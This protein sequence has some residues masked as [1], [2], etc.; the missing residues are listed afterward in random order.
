MDNFDLDEEVLL[1]EW[2][3]SKDRE[4]QNLLSEYGSS[5]KEVREMFPQVLNAVEKRDLATV[6]PN[7][8]IFLS[9]EEAK[10]VGLGLDTGWMLK[11]TPSQKEG[12]RYTSSLITPE[13]WEITEDD[14]FI[15][16]SGEKYTRDEMEQALKL[17]N[18]AV[19]NPEEYAAQQQKAL[20]IEEVFGKVFPKQDV[21]EVINYAQN[22]L[23][24]FYKDIFNIGRNKDTE[25]LLKLLNFTDEE[26]NQF[27]GTTAPVQFQEENWL[28]D[29]VLDPLLSGTVNFAYG[30]SQTF[31]STL[32]S[33]L[34]GLYRKIR[35]LQPAADT[36]LYKQEQVMLNNIEQWSKEQ[37]NRLVKENNDWWQKHPELTPRPEYNENPF[38]KTELL[39][40]PGYYAYSFT[41]SLAY[42]LAT[43]G[44]MVAVSALASP[45]AG[46]PA[47]LIVAGAPEAGRM[48]EE[49]V[50]QGVPIDEANQWGLLYGTVAGGIETITDLP[51]LGI[52]FKPIKQAAKPFW[53]TLLKGTSNRIAKAVITTGVLPSVEGME[54]AVTQAAENAILKHFD[55]TK[56][57]ME[58]LDQSFIQGAI[59]SLPF[60]VVGG[61]ASFSTFHNSLNP[62]IRKKFDEEMAKFQENGLSEEEAQVKAANEVAKTPEGEKAVED[63]LNTAKNEFE[64]QFQNTTMGKIEGTNPKYSVPVGGDFGIGTK[65]PEDVI[66]TVAPLEKL[67]SDEEIIKGMLV[68]NWIRTTV[69]A[70]AKIPKIGKIVEGG[71]GWRTL[72]NR[73]TK[74]T[75]DIVG[76]G[77][78]VYGTIKRTGVG[79]ANTEVGILRNLIEKPVQYFGFNEQG[80]SEKMARRL[81]PQYKEHK[82]IAGTLEHVFTY[83]E[84]YDWT[85]M[86]KAMDYIA[87]VNRINKWVNKLLSDEGA[88]V[89]AV[90]ERWIHRVVTGKTVEGELVEVRGRKGMTGG[91]PGTV[92]SYKKPRKFKTMMEGIQNHII[93]EPNIEV[94]VG[95]Y[96]EEAFKEIASTRFSKSVEEFGVTPKERLLERYPEVAAKAELTKEE[97]A[98]AAKF[99]GVINRAIRGEI[100][101]EATI[102]EMERKFPE[103][104]PKL[105]YY[106]AEAREEA[107]TA[108]NI[109][110]LKEY[111]ITQGKLPSSQKI[112]D[113]LKLIPYDERLTLRSQLLDFV[114]RTNDAG[115]KRILGIISDIDSNPMYI[116][117]TDTKPA[118]PAT[119]PSEKIVGNLPFTEMPISQIKVDPQ[120]FQ[121]K[122]RSSEVTGETGVLAQAKWN[123]ELAGITYGWQAKDG[124]VYIVNGHQRL[125][126]A[127]RSGAKTIPIRIDKEVDGVTEQE[128]RAKGA[129]INI[130]EDRG[131][132]FDVAKFLRDSG[133]DIE[134]L[135]QWGITPEGRLA[136]EGS[137]IAG[138]DDSVYRKVAI[139]ELDE[140]AA[141]IIGKELPGD[142]ANQRAIAKEYLDKQLTYKQLSAIIKEAKWAGTTKVTQATLF[143]ETE[144]E[145]SMLL[146]RAK[147][148]VA[149]EDALAKDKRLFSYVTA[150]GRPEALARGK[151]VVDV[152]TG[153]KLAQE[154]ATALAIFEAKANAVGV[155]DD[156]MRDASEKIAKGG[157]ANVITRETIDRIRD[158][159]NSGEALG[160]TRYVTTDEGGRVPEITPNRG[161]ATPAEAEATRAAEEARAAETVTEAGISE[162]GM[163]QVSAEEI[164]KKFGADIVLVEELIRRGHTIAPDGTMTLYHATTKD[165]AQRILSEGVL[166]TA[167][168]APDTYGVYLSTSPEVAESYGDGTLIKIKVKIKDLHPDDVFPSTGRM[169]FRVNTVSGV[170]HPVEVAQFELTPIVTEAVTPE[171]TEAQLKAKVLE[172]IKDTPEWKKLVR[173]YKAF[174]K[175][176]HGGTIDEEAIT[177][178][179]NNPENL[180]HILT[181]ESGVMD[182]KSS[183][184]KTLKADTDAV[185]KKAGLTRKKQGKF[186]GMDT[187]DWDAYEKKVAGTIYST[188][189]PAVTPEEEILIPRAEPGM[190]EPGLQ[191]D[192]FGYLTPVYPKG[193]GEITQISMDDYSKL[194]DAYKQAEL[195]PPEVEV[196]PQVEGQPGLEEPTE[197]KKETYTKPITKSAEER[198]QELIKLRDE[199][200][201]IVDSRKAPFWQAKH[202]MAEKMEIVRRPDIGE[203]YLMMPFAGGR[204]FNQDFVD[205]VN[206]F[207]GVDKGS[208]TLKFVSDAAGILRIT[209]ASLDFSAM[210]IQGLPSF[211][212]AHTQLI[213]NPATGARLM[214]AWYKALYDSTRAFFSPSVFYG[215]LDKQ[216]KVAAQRNSFGG[217]SRSIDYFD[218]LRT[219][220]AIPE[221]FR[222]VT[223]KTGLAALYE[224]AEISFNSAGEI[225]RDEFWK[226]LSPKALKQGKGFEL[227]RHMD[228][229]TGLSET[230]A[231]GVPLTV[232]QLE[233]SFA[234]FAPN[235]TRA[236][237]TVVAD[238][239]RGGY[240]GKMARQALGGMLAA[241]A[242]YYT[243][244]QLA[245]SLL[246]GK[247]EDDAWDE[248]KKGFGIREDPITGEI[249][250]RPL[251]DLMGIKIGN[252]TFG[253]GG[254]WY[255][256][257]RLAGNINECIN[258]YGDKERID[259][260][261]ILANGGLNKDNPFVYWWYSRSSPL[262]GM[263]YELA[264]H[265]DFLGY[266]IETPEQ[267]AYYIMSRFE[268]IWME[269]GINWM[270]PGLVRNYEIPEGVARAA[271]P[272]LEVFGWRSVP[273]SSW[274]SF[275]DYVNENI[276]N[277]LPESE[278]DP[279]QVKAW[280]DGKLGWGELDKKQKRDLIDRDPELARLYEEANNDSKIRQTPEWEAYTTRTDEEREIYYDRIDELTKRLQAG[281]IDT[282][283]YRELT[284]EAGT[285]YGAIMDGISRDEHYSSIFEYFEKKEAEGSKYEFLFDVALAEY[286]SKIRFAEDADIYLS[287]GDYNWEERDRRIDAFI[288]K[289]GQTLYDEILDYINKGKEIKGLNPVFVRKS[290]DTEKLGREYWRLPYKPIIEM[291][292]EDEKEGNIPAEYYGLW[293]TFQSLA[294]EDKEG[295]AQLYPD[296]AKDWRAE[297]RKNNPEADARL[298]LWGYGGKLQ[299]MEAYNLVEQWSKE[300]GIPLSQ[301]GLGLPPRTLIPKYF[302]YS[303]LL[304]NYSAASPQVKIWRLQNPEFNKWAM[305]EWGWEGT[306]DYRSVEYYQLKIKNQ[307][308]EKEYNAIPSENTIAKQ[309]YLDEHPDFRD[310]RYRMRAMDWG[311]PTELIEQYVEYYNTPRKDY[312][313]DWWLMEHPEFEKAM[314]QLYKDTEGE[315]GWE[316]PRDYSKV[317]TK[318]VYAKYQRYLNLPLG[319]PRL[320]FRARNPDLDA[321]GVKALDWK[322]IQDR[323]KK[324]A[325]K[326]P[327][328]EAGE[329]AQLEEWIKELSQ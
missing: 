248:V 243:G 73:D 236:C 141:A 170:Y 207:F 89:D 194:V 239:F 119:P 58:G 155:I 113:T 305:E 44:T 121:F 255:G 230:Q 157:K 266:P 97:L 61:A 199:V 232:R 234:W 315:Y 53:D 183:T 225:V 46:I 146:A 217:T 57:I 213:S 27:F 17:S 131:T 178:Y 231:M 95:S 49:L 26:I 116:P 60:S 304:T 233:S 310:D 150:T 68:P 112:R 282:Q 235:Y 317:P 192:M 103:L 326:T 41:Q 316:K 285:N 85:N 175:R 325:P 253:P 205:A 284:S 229:I 216:E 158:A 328:E 143:G 272:I 88:G 55:E 153:K 130:A 200:K 206:K 171:I 180:D 228:I 71:L 288:E 134:Y 23:E 163:P 92:P 177:Q 211:G 110:L 185:L 227:A 226:I 280:Q 16:P 6:F 50:N 263:G 48:T 187:P 202:E 268:P 138:L 241:G 34:T 151:T 7:Q 215:Y 265:K 242:V 161:E 168:K 318:E 299:S 174:E 164:A 91:R 67:P 264:T 135:K 132:P 256:L 278:L 259:L 204:I 104:G 156:I 93:Y 69:Q 218:A 32:P 78:V 309:K 84:M 312:E 90:N 294:E 13:K 137:A 221:G 65:D 295:F 125:A 276:K 43:M 102:A 214:G 109:K 245:I 118:A 152:E 300:L 303:D 287:N 279:K 87:R 179:V 154:S 120:R 64:E 80:Y 29:N 145:K 149:V 290:E 169:D 302:E 31:T 66:K 86:D 269:Q 224:R 122:Q 188:E 277:L 160:P 108:R 297:Y 142:F 219:R 76:R 275:Y 267:Y 172:E 165:K 12:E 79:I 159:I 133:K 38:K 307:P 62:D 327:W 11:L 2:T 301:M 286:N 15:A 70:T 14:L 222:W 100:L 128:A 244:I 20:K 306:D 273:E 296:L 270:I 208:D 105:R 127:K 191:Q 59:A 25:D 42:S 246:S 320:D 77:A 323:G 311:F 181:A 190:P 136:S 196:K 274:T 314:V 126:L 129:I 22:N 111:P 261:R 37:Y 197:I 3:K 147:L 9:A 329:A 292:A 262:V 4:I 96:I 24:S 83:P 167:D 162:A 115:G 139:G 33:F 293:K 98:S 21:A 247:D 10:S 308:F 99:Q 81:L 101:P 75:Q 5:L 203:N 144:T 123:P 19:T 220:G 56:S 107:E 8:D 74:A 271:V 198:R 36:E 240:S 324:E 148:R 250:W 186:R 35:A 140:H 82:D 237:L 238:I 223:G 257:V 184:A 72:V 106:I 182:A 258:E 252:Y 30:M 313:D 193:K 40:D 291:D 209:K 54:E 1:E 45:A 260:V 212:L 298:A 195:P 321:W 124:T 18:L 176:L 52:L 94:S 166:K 51:L 283:Q 114:S 39:T 322:P 319:Q 251:S 173:D 210:M 189:V 117:K 254:F 63:A 289:Y 281:E 28:K 249:M 47:G 201:Q